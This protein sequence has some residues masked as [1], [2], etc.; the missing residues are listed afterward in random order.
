MTE[1]RAAEIAGEPR[2]LNPFVLPQDKLLVTLGHHFEVTLGKMLDAGKDSDPSARRLPYVRAA[3]IQ[4]SGLKLDDVNSMPFSNE[5]AARLNLR[6]GDLLV[7][8][9]GAVGTSVV[10][11]A[12]MPDWS[13]QKTVNRVRATRQASTKWLAY[14]LLAYRDAGVIDIVCNKSTIPHLTAEKLRGLRIP[15]MPPAEQQHVAD[16]LDRETAQIDTL[17]KAQQRLIATLRERRI[18]AATAELSTQVGR[19]DRVKW[20]FAEL[21]VRAGLDAEHLPLLSVSIDWGVRRRDETTI[22]ESRAEDLSNYKVCRGGD[23]V[24]NRMRAFQ[25]ALGVASED[26]LTSPDYAVLR[27]RKTVDG[28]W[29]AAT[30]RTTAFVAEM[31]SRVKGIGS[32]DLGAARTPRINI[33]DLGE[34]RI[35][36][37]PLAEQL[38]Q[39]AAVREQTAKIDV[40]I[41]EAERFIELS[42]ERRSALITAA[43]TGQIDV[44]DEAA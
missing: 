31:A 21:D 41:T 28:A 12:D 32:A 38:K 13:F 36:I 6:A 18:A 37:P 15:A 8:E 1:A 26:G 27:T 34:I 20:A 24:I 39:L 2:S 40:L 10:I 30:M 29:L 42:R 22:N 43:V 33:A 44:R 7:V 16:Y 4:D 14:V 35:A 23:L 9:G 19:G 11:H 25:G 5:E 17:I 3:N